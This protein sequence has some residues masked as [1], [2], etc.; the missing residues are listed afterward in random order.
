MKDIRELFRRSQNTLETGGVEMPEAVSC[1]Y[2]GKSVP[3]EVWMRARRVCPSCGHHDRLPVRERIALLCDRFDER[4]AE[5]V[6]S[7]PLSFPGYA[8]KLRRAAEASGEAEG[9][10]CGEAVI[11][12]FRTALFVMDPAFMMGS[13]GTAVGEKIARLFDFASDNA[14]P[15]IGVTASGGARMQEG[16]LSLMQMAKVSCA[17]RRHSDSGLFYAAVLTDPTTGGVT[18]SF[19]MQADVLLA[20]PRARI[21]FA[22]RRV[23]EQTT[24]T[25][26]P[27]DFQSAE[28]QLAHGFLDRIVPR[29][30]LKK[31]L[32]RLLLLHNAPKMEEVL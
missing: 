1:P 29:A 23:I 11:G 13:M 22:G 4:D 28:F 5:I 2:C 17:V 21:G 14:L 32:V 10:L 12:G 25:K 19:A 26:L 15:V 30:E 16:I 24:R 7:D 8:E 6:S 27:D 20:E 18:A 3:E 9:V 31:T